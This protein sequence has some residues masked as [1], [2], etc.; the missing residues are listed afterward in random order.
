VVWQ[1]VAPRIQFH[2]YASSYIIIM[3]IIKITITTTIITSGR[4]NFT[5]G[6]IAAAHG[7]FNGI[8]GTLLPSGEYI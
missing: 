8:E 4:S 7:R 6:R 1:H 5:T 3:M 2:A